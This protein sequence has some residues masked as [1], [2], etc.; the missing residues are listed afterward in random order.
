MVFP[1]LGFGAENESSDLAASAGGILSDPAAKTA[2][3][4]A[5]NPGSLSG[6]ISKEKMPTMK[7]SVL[8]LG[9]RRDYAVPKVFFSEGVL[10]ML[11]TDL[12]IKG[13][14]INYISKFPL[15]SYFRFF[16]N[17][18][19]RNDRGLDNAPIKRYILFSIIYWI[20]QKI[21]K[22]KNKRFMFSNI[23]R[24]FSKK[25][26]K[27]NDNITLSS[28]IYAWQGLGVEIFEE[29][30][31]QAL[32]VQD[33][34]LPVYSFVE[35]LLTVERKNW[36]GWEPYRSGTNLRD[37]LTLRENRERELAD[38]ILVPTE[39]CRT[40][41]KFQPY[42]LEKARIVPYPVNLDDLKPSTRR[43]CPNDPLKVLFLGNLTLRKGIHY[44]LE[45]AAE[46]GPK[47]VRVRAV[48]SIQ[49]APKK[50]R[51]YESVAEFPGR[52]PRSWVA[53]ELESTDVLCLPSLAEAQGL[54]TS[55]ALAAGVPVILTPNAG[56]F[57][58]NGIDGIEVPV[59]D[60]GA[61]RDAM[62]QYRLNPGLLEWQSNN[63]IKDRERLGIEKYRKKL[64]DVIQAS[65]EKKFRT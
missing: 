48:G 50:L 63:A 8:Q 7:V 65:F 12:Y 46:I 29:K 14:E 34:N 30:I 41:L 21:T 18:L 15:V 49:V 1:M 6:G 60:I 57:V 53:K 26:T 39:F 31:N 55:E 23:N 28:V 5:A 3:K 13:N 43:Y 58:R 40:S 19:G 11:Y 4:S 22:Q 37:P 32:L 38:L 54:V 59:R 10:K 52:V 51:K 20:K 24:K 45:A 62:N 36:R 2:G 27:D 9:A 33:M 25:V 47:G 35:D 42:I 64:I 56:A 61:L 17:I 44:L 16:Q